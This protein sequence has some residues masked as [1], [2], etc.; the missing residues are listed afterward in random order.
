ME[1]TVSNFPKMKPEVNLEH[2]YVFY[3]RYSAAI[4]LTR[5]WLVARRLTNRFEVN[6]DCRTRSDNTKQRSSKRIERNT[7]QWSRYLP[8]KQRLAVLRLW[9]SLKPST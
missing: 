9:N 3:L 7:L 1:K 4:C 6:V 5:A 8:G 2:G